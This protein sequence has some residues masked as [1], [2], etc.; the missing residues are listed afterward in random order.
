MSDLDKAVETQLKNIQAK[1]GKSMDELTAI[2][3]N[4]GLTKHSEIRAMLQRDLGLGYGDANAL[5]HHVLQSDGT[6][7]AKASGATTEDVLDEIYSGAKAALRPIHDK[8]DGRDRRFW[9]LR[10]CPQE[11]LRQSA[12]QEAIRHDRP[13]YQHPRRSGIEHEGCGGRSAADRTTGRQHVQLHRE[14]DD[15]R[16]SGR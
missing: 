3:R 11:G 7:A 1:T 14:G 12:S 16:R 2:I 4:S 5:V 8:S 13:G 10:D 15:R 6:T 9:R